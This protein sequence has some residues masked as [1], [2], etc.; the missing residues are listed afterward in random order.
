MSYPSAFLL[1]IKKD[2]YTTYAA[3]IQMEEEDA[4]IRC[5]NEF[6]RDASVRVIGSVSVG[7]LNNIVSYSFKEST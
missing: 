5:R 1:E 6:G 7:T 4:I 2:G 3:V